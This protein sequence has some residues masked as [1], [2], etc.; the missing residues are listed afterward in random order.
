[1]TTMTATN[2]KPAARADRRIKRN[3]FLKDKKDKNYV[4]MKENNVYIL[5]INIVIYKLTE[6]VVIIS[7][8]LPGMIRVGLYVTYKN[9]SWLLSLLS[10]ISVLITVHVAVFNR[11]TQE[12]SSL[13]MNLILN[14]FIKLNKSSNTI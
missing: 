10:L 1:M 5:E 2:Q 3:F 12:C 9:S 14:V 13:I 8:V 4:Q 7:P 6:A 11:D